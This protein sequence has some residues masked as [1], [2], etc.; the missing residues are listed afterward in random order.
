MKQHK[1][2]SPKSIFVKCIYK[3]E[4]GPFKSECWA[5]QAKRFV[6]N[7][8]VREKCRQVASNMREQKYL[9]SLK[10]KRAGKTEIIYNCS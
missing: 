4:S 3:E 8:L 2:K 10:L 1:R 5:R 9:C 6:R 7:C